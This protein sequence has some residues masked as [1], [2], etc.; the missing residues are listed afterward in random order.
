[1]RQSQRREEPDVVEERRARGATN[2]LQRS[3]KKSLV[4][5]VHYT[6]EAWLDTVRR[7]VTPRQV[8]AG[9]ESVSIQ[10]PIHDITTMSILGRGCY[11]SLSEP[12]RHLA[13][14]LWPADNTTI[15]PTN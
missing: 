1:M 3:T 9:T 5:Y 15:E 4:V 10:K 7:V 8:R 13:N 14:L 6:P 11:P 2:L 12:R